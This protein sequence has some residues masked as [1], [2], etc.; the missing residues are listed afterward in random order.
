MKSKKEMKKNRSK[1]FFMGI[2]LLLLA[3][4]CTDF[5]DKEPDDQLDIKMIFSS[6]NNVEKWLAGM[7]DG[8]P[9]PYS[10]QDVDAMGDNLAPSPRWEQFGFTI[11]G[12][13]TGNWSASSK[14]YP[15]FWNELPKRIRSSYILIKNVKAIPE[16]GVMERDVN[17]M[18]AEAKFLIAYYHYLLLS[19]FGS[20]PLIKEAYSE[21]VSNEA[22]MEKQVPF[23]SAVEWIDNLLLEA[24][25]ELPPL[26]TE[27]MKYGRATSIMCLAIRTKLLLLAASP[28]VNGN[29]DFRKVVN[30]DNEP[31]FNGTP[32]PA[33]WEK[34]AAICKKLIDVAKEN[35]HDIYYEYMKDGSIDPFL[36]Y[37]NVL[38][39]GHE[40]GNKEILMSRNG[41]TYNY[42]DDSAQPRGTGG[43]GAMGI[44]QLLVDAFFM[45]DGRR[46]ILGYHAD[47]SPMIN[48]ESTYKEKGFSSSDE[49]RK[50]R[51]KESQ[52]DVRNEENKVT[53]KGTFNMY[54]NREPR[55]YI[56]VLYN[57]AWFNRAN[58]TTDF[59]SF[60]ADGGPSHDAPQN[61]YLVRKKVDPDADPVNGKH[62][63]RVGIVYRLAEAYLSY[64]EALNEINYTANRD[65]VLFYLNIIRERAGIPKYGTAYGELPI[66]AGQVE[67][68]EAILHERWVELN[69][70][71]GTRFD[72]IRRWKKGFDCL[73]GP[74]WGMNFAGTKKS[75]DSSDPEAY[76]VRKVYQT[77]K[78]RSYWM[79]IPQADIDKN[80]N[81]IQLPG[82]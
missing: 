45:K 80:P 6:K 41:T 8:I 73:D 60:G 37:Q 5:L 34:A 13:Q 2:A 9:N 29:E 14:W 62:L 59:Y 51:W 74:F 17:Y 35:G 1:F 42:Y 40:K 24:E 20:I 76:F 65:E 67:M 69:C 22:V 7:Y 11:I 81:L 26:Y 19:Y 78:F 48:Q 71:N 12:Y 38:M 25:R 18:K 4:S 75:D 70:E 43:A 44:T 32:D 31:I 77:R 57:G 68:R 16:E 21:D 82:W 33:K 66:P 54:C 50:T 36:S 49:V 79:P 28:L 46:P 64:A 30:V 15:D 47:G 63:F 53:L 58:R 39:N 56:S 27:P 10:Y 3:T 23:D 55:F 72:D 61:G 52:G